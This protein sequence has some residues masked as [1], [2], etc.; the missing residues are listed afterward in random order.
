MLPFLVCP[1]VYSLSSHTIAVW[2]APDD[3]YCVLFAT[4]REVK[5]NRLLGIIL[6]A[7]NYPSDDFI[8]CTWDSPRIEMPEKN[9]FS[10]PLKQLRKGKK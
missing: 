10:K 7:R 4:G 3:I 5:A 8:F 1:Q 2:N 9:K 6:I